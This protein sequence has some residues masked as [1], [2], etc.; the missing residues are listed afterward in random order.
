M[1][2]NY[3]ELFK[4]V[5]TGGVYD[6]SAW[7]FLEEEGTV[8]PPT[9]RRRVATLVARA[10]RK[11]GLALVRRIPFDRARRDGGE[12]WPLCGYT[13]I[14][15]ARLD[16][17]QHCLETALADGVPG[18]F[19][20]TGVW[21]GGA[22]MLARAVLDAHGAR[23]RTVWLA[24]SFVGLP[25]PRYAGDGA[26]ISGSR[27]LAV[28]EEQ[29]RRN[30]ARFGLLGGNVRWLPGWFHETLPGA[31]IDRLAVLRLD[32]DLHSSTTE[33]LTHLYHRVSP[34]GFV[35]V[36]DYLSWPDCGRAVREFLDRIGEQPQLVPIDHNGVFWR[37]G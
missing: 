21:R 8:Q 25:R 6:E 12:D 24:D 32:G 34:G 3:L 22:C 33:A 13:M 5:L 28:S 35:I 23:D 2:A 16:N 9:W 4:E 19:I 15:R 7:T 36:D 18:D 29:V 37:K 17:L 1:D 14:G 10:C 31:P 11:H 30:F 20:E 26:D 27:L